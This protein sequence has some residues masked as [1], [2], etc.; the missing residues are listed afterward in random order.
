[1]PLLVQTTR[2]FLH[3]L[4]LHFQVLLG[5]GSVDPILC[6]FDQL[7]KTTLTWITS[8][9]ERQDALRTQTDKPHNAARGEKPQNDI[10]N[11]HEWFE[12]ATKRKSMRVGFTSLDKPTEASTEGHF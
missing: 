5:R 12:R 11:F 6:Q 9:D 10:L 8:L 2:N 3:L 7:A 1:M 4:Q